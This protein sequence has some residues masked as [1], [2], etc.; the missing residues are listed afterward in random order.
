[1]EDCRE[2]V[3]FIKPDST[4]KVTGKSNGRTEVRILSV[5]SDLYH[6]FDKQ[7]FELIQS[8]VVAQR[9]RQVFNTKTKSW[10]KAVETSFYV[11]NRKLKAAQ[12]ASLVRSHWHIENR[13]HHVRDQTLGED[14]SRI[15]VH[16]GVMARLRSFSLNIL[17]LNNEQNIRH[18]VF[19]NALNFNRLYLYQHCI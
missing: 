8:V 11:S 2:A 5:Y 12:A 4:S 1:M 3:R 9:T 10:D 19:C 16:P 15:R 7:W 6:I 13:N 14:Q 17:R 18:A